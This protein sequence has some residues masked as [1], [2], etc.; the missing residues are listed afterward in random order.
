MTNLLPKMIPRS[1]LNVKLNE[2]LD[3]KL[4][5][6]RMQRMRNHPIGNENSKRKG[7]MITRRI[8]RKKGMIVMI[9]ILIRILM[10]R[11]PQEMMMMI[12]IKKGK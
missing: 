5:V 2:K 10:M 1:V 11:I 4:N 7:I 12:K 3:V 8:R 9:P 6:S